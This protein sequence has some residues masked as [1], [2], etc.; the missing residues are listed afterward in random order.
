MT[1]QKTIRVTIDPCGRP[2]IDAMGFTGASC[3]KATK[4]IEDALGAKPGEATMVAKP[5]M[6]QPETNQG[7]MTLGL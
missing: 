3:S 6:H 1:G 4:P 7:G 2:K 5:E